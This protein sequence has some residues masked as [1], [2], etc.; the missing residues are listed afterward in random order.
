MNAIDVIMTARKR[1]CAPS[2]AA[3]AMPMPASRC[4]LANSTI[5]MPFFAAS[6]INTTRPIWA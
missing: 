5:R 4:S 2:A 6:A 1:I 3:S